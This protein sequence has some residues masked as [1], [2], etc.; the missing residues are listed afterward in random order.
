MLL[1]DE[2]GG[3]KGDK[4]DE[5]SKAWW[6]GDGGV[7]VKKKKEERSGEEKMEEGGI[8]VR[9][10]CF[11]NIQQRMVLLIGK[12]RLQYRGKKFGAASL[13]IGWL[14]WEVH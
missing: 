3:C 8:G 9:W 7:V 14:G 4:D 11:S 12:A 6:C 2:G 10:S 5:G 13:A 1:F